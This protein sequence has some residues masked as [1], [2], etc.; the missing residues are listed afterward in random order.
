[1]ATTSVTGSG[2]DIPSLVSQ[3]VTAART[4]TETRINNAGTTATTKLSAIS[5]VK[6]SMTTLQTALNKVISSADTSAYKATIEKDAGFTAT[7][8]STAV[9]GSYSVEVVKLAT[10]QKLSSTAYEK[11]A[12]VGSGKLTFSYGDDKSFDIEIG[13]DDKLAD[14]AAAINKAAGGKGVV[15]SVV[16]ADD[17]QHLVFSA[18]DSGTKG[19]LTVTASDD[20]VGLQG[21]TFA[22]GASGGMN[23]SI[24]AA[25]AVVRV[26]GF[27][28]TES[29]N[30]ITDLVPG[31]VL[32]LTKAAE[33]TNF[34]LSIASDS[35]TLKANLTAFAAAYNAANTLLKSSTA[36]NA[37]TKTAST[38]TG[39]SLIRS[40]QQQLRGSVS[41]N[42]TEL[43]ALGI[44]LDKD[45]VM[46]FD[47]TKLDTVLATEPEAAKNMFGKDGTFSAG[48]SKMLDSNL[49][50]TSGTLTLR[51]NSLNA[52]IKDLE[53]QLDTLDT[54][55]EKLSDQYTA[56][57][58]AMETM[59]TQ[60][61]SSS[62]SLSSLLSSS[63]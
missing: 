31:V 30:T 52:Q 25:D 16:T 18:T 21:L 24:A 22:A 4:P 34:N 47:G 39:D 13:A 60:L 29:S 37:D 33:G 17:G 63:T 27:E 7:T 51:T 44:T 62:S 50:S 1:M 19:A 20:A 54:R 53:K 36:Y 23:E 58:T 55:M 10:N 41:A 43:K 14:I 45:G 5:Q 40:M 12:T 2:L 28:R 8:T 57:F 61:Q 48:L 32:N 26:D 59:I 15:A 56:Q 42:L 9:T 3:L 35:T 46:S 11:D 38:L 6:S 49:N